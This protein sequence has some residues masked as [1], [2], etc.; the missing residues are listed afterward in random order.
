MQGF[1]GFA[2]QLTNQQ[3]SAR[4]VRLRI[5][6]GSIKSKTSALT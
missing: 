6:F 4:P 3:S 1:S 5:S 2:L